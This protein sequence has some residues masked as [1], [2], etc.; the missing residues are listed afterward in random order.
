MIDQRWVGKRTEKTFFTIS[1]KE[2]RAYCDVIGEKNPIYLHVETAHLNGYEDVLIPPT[3]S[4]ILWQKVTI[5]WMEEDALL[6]Q[7]EQSFSYRKAL[8]ANKQYG[9]EIVLR[10]IREHGTKQYA[11]HDLLVTEAETTVLTSTITFVVL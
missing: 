7:R 9:C 2:V 10:K 11:M 3:Y 1:R 8:I 5:P 4:S 6:L